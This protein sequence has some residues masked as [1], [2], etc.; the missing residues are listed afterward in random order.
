MHF[1]SARFSLA[2]SGKVLSQ[3]LMVIVLHV[4]ASVCVFVQER[5]Q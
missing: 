1:R 4:C 5:D 3:C 2:E